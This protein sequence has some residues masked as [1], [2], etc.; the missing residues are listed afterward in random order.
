MGGDDELFDDDPEASEL[1][2]TNDALGWA[3]AP[4]PVTRKHFKLSQLPGRTLSST[5]TI[6]ADAASVTVVEDGEGGQLGLEAVLESNLG[7]PLELDE[8]TLVL[9][10]ADGDLLDIADH[11]INTKF[12][13]SQEVVCDFRFG[14]S[15]LSHC[16]AIELLVD[17]EYE[18][19]SLVAVANTD[20]VD[21]LGEEFHRNRFDVT[22]RVSPSRPGFPTFDVRLT[23]FVGY[24]W[25]SEIEVIIELSE[26]GETDS[27][28]RDVVIA[29]RDKSGTIMT[30]ETCS[31]SRTTAATGAVGKATLALA[32]NQIAGLSRIDVGVSGSIERRELLGAFALVAVN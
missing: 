18:F 20:G 11:W 19:Q 12:S 8:L 5:L 30:R 14:P 7:K 2:G 21:F 6:A 31:L 9:R 27:T 16:R 3:E 29:L 22:T 1:F 32:P 15:V 25:E 10:D 17:Y 24:T 28:S 4:G 13:R 26:V 23:G